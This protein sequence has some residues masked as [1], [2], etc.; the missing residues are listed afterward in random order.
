MLSSECSLILH[1]A[2]LH[3]ENDDILHPEH[4]TPHEISGN[5]ESPP[6]VP[7]PSNIRCEQCSFV[8]VDDHPSYVIS[9]AK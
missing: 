1:L 8:A 2:S 5:A 7:P 6:S 9:H 4:D 3:A